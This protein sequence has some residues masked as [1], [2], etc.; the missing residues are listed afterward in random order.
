MSSTGRGSDR[1]AFDFYSTP[2]WCVQRLV[3]RIRLPGDPHGY[4]L[5]PCAGNGAIPMAMSPRRWVLNEIRESERC[6]LE[7]LGLG[8]VTIGDYGNLDTGDLKISAI[9]TNPPFSIAF[10]LLQWCLEK[11]PTAI[12]ILLQR[13]N[14]IGSQKR[15]A[16][17][18]R[19]M[20]DI[21]VLPN[22]PAF[23]GMAGKTDS[24]E[25]AWFVWWPGL[26]SGNGGIQLLDLTTK[27]ERQRD[28]K[29]LDLLG[30]K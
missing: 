22:R 18:S 29:Q 12:L 6:T 7:S 30:G 23:G 10:D 27:E 1:K 21:Y 19:R 13:L 2:A 28:T 15:F 11:Y 24:I 17:F 5:E 8:P 14:F 16:E 9:I 26:R 3:D 4:W 20:P 25:Y